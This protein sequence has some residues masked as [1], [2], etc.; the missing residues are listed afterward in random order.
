MLC[1]V[2]NER[3]LRG[4][5]ILVTAN[6]P[7]PRSVTCSMIL[8]LA[9]ATLDRLPQARPPLRSTRSPVSSPSPQIH[10]QNGDIFSRT[11]MRQSKEVLRE[12]YL[13]FG[14]RQ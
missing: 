4:W 14:H 3:Y 12:L 10:H 13:V 8:D 5:P 11:H 9:E 6:K 2:V 1:R 7:W